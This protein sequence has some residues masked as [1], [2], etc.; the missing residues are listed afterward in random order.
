M[1]T[2]QV[3]S[4]Y[5]SRRHRVDSFI[6]DTYSFNRARGW[7]WLQRLALW[8][9]NKLKCYAINSVIT[10]TRHTVELPKLIEAIHRQNSELLSMYDLRGERLLIG[11]KEFSDLMNSDIYNLVSFTLPYRTSYSPTI[12]GMKVT[13]IPWMSGL[14]VLPK[15]LPEPRTM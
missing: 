15:E 13:V 6:P 12:M 10:C 9:L 5:E 3:V 11:A 7:V 4:F 2:Q 8:V 14:L 1:T